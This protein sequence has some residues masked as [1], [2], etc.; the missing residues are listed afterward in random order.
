MHHPRAQVCLEPMLDALAQAAIGE[1]LAPSALLGRIGGAN[2]IRAALTELASTRQP[3]AAA[4]AP[5]RILRLLLH[6]DDAVVIYPAE[7][8]ESSGRRLA[9][10]LVDPTPILQGGYSRVHASLSMSGTLAAPSDNDDELRYQVPILG[11]PSEGTVTRKYA[12][13]FPLRN[14]RWIYCPDTLGTYRER[15]AHVR[16]YVEHITGVG[17]A[18]P[19]VTAVFF[20][21]YSFLEQVQAGIPASEQPLIVAESRADA[22]GEDIPSDL[23]AY[24]TRLRQLVADHGRA[25]LFGVYQGK[26]AEGA[27]FRGNL[28]KTVVCVSIPMEYPAL[29]HQRMEALYANRFA[30]IA[31]ALGDDARAKARE[32]ARDRL[33]LSLVLQACGRGIRGEG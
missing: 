31:E 26:L 27:D 13:P 18:T 24:E 5:E 12:S 10:R 23:G 17:Q 9:F 19:G 33:S 25:Y 29:F 1:G 22:R 6:P 21:S 28:L 4:Q 30:E 16:R 2:A 20:S 3:D 7:D 32:Y 14:Q 15:G 11:L 8:S